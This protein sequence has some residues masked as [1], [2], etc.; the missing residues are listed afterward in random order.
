[1]E[2]KY[3]TPEIE[4]FHIGFEYQ[5]YMITTG[6]YVIMDM[7]NQEFSM[8]KEPT[9]HMWFTT[10]FRFSEKGPLDTPYTLEQIKEFLKEDR[11]RV[12]ELDQE[13]LESLGWKYNG[14]GWYDL[15]KV[16]GSLGYFTHVKFKF[17]GK[18]TF[19][20]AYRGE[21]N[22]CPDEEQQHLFVGEIKNKSELKRIMKQVQIWEQ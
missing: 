1:M 7:T 12:K 22:T 8:V 18:E 9:E 21:P 19:I 14:A 11:I 4:E 3:Y 20:K 16:P 17:W 10:T 6:G 15:I 5:T 13:D 2:T